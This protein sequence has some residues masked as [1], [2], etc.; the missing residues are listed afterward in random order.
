MSMHEGQDKQFADLTGW[1][2]QWKKASQ[3]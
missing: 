1:V 2:Q 3:H